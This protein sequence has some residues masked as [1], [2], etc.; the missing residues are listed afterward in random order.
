LA[1]EYAEVV[2]SVGCAHGRGENC[3]KLGAADALVHAKKCPFRSETI[4][5]RV[6]CH[7]VTFGRNYVDKIMIGL[8][9]GKHY[10]NVGKHYLNFE[11]HSTFTPNCRICRVY[12]ATLLERSWHSDK[13]R[14]IT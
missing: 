10:L 4:D 2:A 7:I 1:F 8:N 14:K 3:G 13:K 5:S 11:D 6:Y 9:V 12:M